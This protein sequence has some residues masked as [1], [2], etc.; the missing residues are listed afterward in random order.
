MFGKM[1]HMAGLI[2]D[3]LRKMKAGLKEGMNAL[4]R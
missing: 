4:E 3:P 1:Q 2:K